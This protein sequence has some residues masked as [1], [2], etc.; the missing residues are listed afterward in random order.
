[1]PLNEIKIDNANSNGAIFNKL[2]RPFRASRLSLVIKYIIK[3]INSPAISIYT[4]YTLLPLFSDCPR[5]SLPWTES[6][7][8]QVGA[9][10]IVLAE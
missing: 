6:K 9:V 10:A 1:M 7:N 2:A 8:G 4:F 5:P 3:M